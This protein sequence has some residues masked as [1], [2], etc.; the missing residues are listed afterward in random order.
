MPRQSNVSIKYHITRDSE[1]L[2]MLV[3]TEKAEHF[4][5]LQIKLLRL[6]EEKRVNRQYFRYDISTQ[7]TRRESDHNWPSISIPVGTQCL[8]CVPLSGN[9]GVFELDQTPLRLLLHLAG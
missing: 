1:H 3:V 6:S 2:M 4:A 8:K 9:L 5:G 7:S